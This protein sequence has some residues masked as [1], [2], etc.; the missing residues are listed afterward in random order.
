MAWYPPFSPQFPQFLIGKRE[1]REAEVGNCFLLSLS[2][3]PPLPADKDMEP[4][5]VPSSGD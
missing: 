1:M 5:T 3:Y 4:E 2:P